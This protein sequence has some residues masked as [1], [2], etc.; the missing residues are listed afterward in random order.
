MAAAHLPRCT[1][2]RRM[3]HPIRRRLGSNLS[4][5]CAHRTGGKMPPPTPLQEVK[6][7]RPHRTGGKM[8]PPTPRGPPRDQGCPQAS[9]LK[10]FGS[11]RLRLGSV[12]ARIG[13]GSDRLRRGSVRLRLGSASARIDFGSKSSPGRWFCYGSAH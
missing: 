9:R 8:R 4:A 6:C 10:I 12:S 3:S 11:D 5:R 1:T 13:F 7:A 2:Q